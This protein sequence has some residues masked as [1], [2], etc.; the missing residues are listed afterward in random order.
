MPEYIQFDPLLRF[1]AAPLPGIAFVSTVAWLEYPRE[2]PSH[3]RQI[4]FDVLFLCHN[5]IALSPILCNILYVQKVE[6]HIEPGTYKVLLKV[7]WLHI[8]EVDQF[9]DL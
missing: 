2:D 9:F 6:E 3:I 7:C 5:N 8:V 1:M 4:C